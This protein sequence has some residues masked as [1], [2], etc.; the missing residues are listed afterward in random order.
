MQHSTKYAYVEAK[1]SDKKGQ[2]ST[3]EILIDI[4]EKRIGMLTAKITKT[5]FK[6]DSNIVEILTEKLVKAEKRLA[7]LNERLD[8]QYAQDNEDAVVSGYTI[9][10]IEHAF[11]IFED[12]MSYD[13]N[14]HIIIDVQNNLH[15]TPQDVEII[16]E[17][18]KLSNKVIDALTTMGYN[19]NALES[20]V[21]EYETGKFHN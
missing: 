3:T 7:K 19:N 15:A 11:S 17:Y 20:V 12:D 9:E 18:S 13:V 1:L 8:I 6:G 14:M 5:E 4:V 10:E 2:I 21:E 16:N